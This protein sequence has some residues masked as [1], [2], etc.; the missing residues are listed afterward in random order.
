VT[1]STRDLT[2]D[3]KATT[4]PAW[5]DRECCPHFLAG[6]CPNQIFTL[7]Q[8]RS[9]LAPCEYAVHNA[10]VRADF[11]KAALPELATYEARLPSI[12]PYDTHVTPL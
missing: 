12:H 8:K 1:G 2:D 5:E 10:A 11:Q 4:R 7:S 9:E 6:M 3:Q